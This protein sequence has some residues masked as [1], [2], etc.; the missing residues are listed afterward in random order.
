MRYWTVAELPLHD[1]LGEPGLMIGC[2][3]VLVDEYDPTTIEECIGHGVP[4]RRHAAG[5]NMGEPNAKKIVWKRR[6]GFQASRS[7]RMK[8]ACGARARASSS[9]SGAAS[10]A[11]TV[12]GAEL[13]LAALP[14][15]LAI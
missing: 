13:D 12:A 11:V 10:T 4:E 6:G 5:R 3:K 2:G 8:V 14:G 15:S 9:I 7:A 1:V